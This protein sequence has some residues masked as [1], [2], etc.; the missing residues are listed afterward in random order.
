MDACG[1]LAELAG[2]RIIGRPRSAAKGGVVEAITAAGEKALVAALT[3]A[4]PGVFVS[5]LEL[6]EDATQP[7]LLYAAD[8]F[9]LRS[10]PPP[11]RTGG[12]PN[13]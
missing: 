4:A 8:P 2:V 11:A 10:P 7:K 9:V 13:G 12:P 3:F 5:A 1:Q 6:A